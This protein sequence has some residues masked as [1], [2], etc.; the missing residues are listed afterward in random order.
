M[1]SRNFQVVSVLRRNFSTYPSMV[2]TVGIYARKNRKH[3][4]AGNSVDV[5]FASGDSA[6]ACDKPSPSH[7]PD[8]KKGKSENAKEPEADPCE[9]KVCNKKVKKSLWKRLFEQTPPEKLPPKECCRLKHHLKC[10]PD[11]SEFGGKAYRTCGPAYI[12]QK[13]ILSAEECDTSKEDLLLRRMEACL[14][15]KDV[16]NEDPLPTFR[17]AETRMLEMADKRLHP[18]YR[19]HC[20]IKKKHVQEQ[21][22]KLYKTV[23]WPIDMHEIP[24]RLNI[25]KDILE[26]KNMEYMEFKRIE[27]P[28]QLIER[29]VE[30]ERNTRPTLE[31]KRSAVQDAVE[32]KPLQDAPGK[33]AVFETLH[34]HETKF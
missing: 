33:G 24:A 3:I 28:R 32:K 6:A 11:L 10:D 8:K 1:A 22:R 30:M 20:H 15:F 18:S 19:T 17:S 21:K 9:Y 27:P 23:S 31:K 12:I 2:S 29:I 14:E 26:K 5:R 4:I 34:Q 13:D 7:A 16:V 25:N